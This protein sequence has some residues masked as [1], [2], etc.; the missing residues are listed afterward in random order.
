M[1]APGQAAPEG[2]GMDQRRG[3]PRFLQTVK[4]KKR[5]RVVF[6][7][8]SIT[9]NKAGHTEMVP[10][11]LRETY[12]DC[13]FTFLNAGLSST[14]STTGAFRLRDQVLSRGPW[15]LLVV[16]FAVN[17]DQD[18]AH[19]RAH[20]IRG[21]EGVIRAFRKANPAGDII[22]VQFVNPQ[23]LEQYQ[24]GEVPVSVQAHKDVAAHYGIPSV[25][26]GRELATEIAAGKTSWEAYGGTHPKKE[27]Y[28]FVSDRII[29]VIRDTSPQAG[30]EWKLPE[31]LDPAN[32]ENGRFLDPQE[33]SWLGGW[34]FAK[35]DK[36]L[37]T[38]GAVRQDYEIYTA[39]RGEE[40][41]TML[42]LSFSGPLLGAFVL[43]GPDAGIL[44]VSVDEEAWRKVDL[45]HHHS[46]GLNYP[47][48]VLLAEGLHGGYHQAAI[49]ISEEKNPAS[50]GNAATI[51]FFEVNPPPLL[52]P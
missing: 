24:K 9:Q 11:W 49:R 41:G 21:L 7:G 44:E 52:K 31:P 45:Y 42:Y 35:P 37:L 47:R 30:T 25:D 1:I 17:D 33:A 36:T 3:T 28:R 43:A 20:C 4:E 29:G 19:D 39:L 48:S 51:L 10:A 46:S 22:S 14:C 50:K 32:Y 12:P 15:D 23:I 34:K 2:S 27:G 5:A 38:Q 18:A 8:G 26:V 13:E 40:A 6:L 16:E